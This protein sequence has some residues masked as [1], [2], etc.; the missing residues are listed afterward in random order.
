MDNSKN[1]IALI[2]IIIV[3]VCLAL[4]SSLILKQDSN[5]TIEDKKLNVG[6]SL[7]VTLKDSHE[8][9]I[10]NQTIK[11]NL[12]E[13]DGSSLCQNITT[14]SSGEVKFKMDKKGKYSVECSF[15]G[16]IHFKSASAEKNITVKQETTKEI[17]EEIT[18]YTSMYDSNGLM[19]PEYGP[20]YD[21]IGTSR[22]EAIA[23]NY[24]YI[25]DVIDGEKIG[26]YTPYDPNAGTY[27]W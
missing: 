12:T 9:P 14:D 11:I 22:E 25:E 3:L 7:T 27:H 2:I 6:D 26:V 24:R 23:G 16:D 8:N 5:L 20:E 18:S 15:T 17:A 19:Y 10:A 1:I 4:F 21:S 13:K